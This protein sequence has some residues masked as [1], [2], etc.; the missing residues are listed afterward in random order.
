MALGLPVVSTNVGGLPYLIDN[1]VDGILVPPNNIQAFKTSIIRLKDD[2]SLITQISNN[3][4]E[5]VE[6]F[7]WNTVKHQWFSILS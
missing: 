2:P 4:R 3:A 1:D 5:K 6:A 7:D